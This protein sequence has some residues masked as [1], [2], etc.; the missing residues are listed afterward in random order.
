MTRTMVPQAPAQPLRR[1][2]DA[3]HPTATGVAHEHLHYDRASRAWRTHAELDRPTLVAW[4]AP[5]T[6]GADFAEVA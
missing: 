5:A 4:T 2:L 6:P 3:L 1:V